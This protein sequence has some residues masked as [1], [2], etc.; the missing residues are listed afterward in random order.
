MAYHS[1]NPVTFAN[2]TVGNISKVSMAAIKTI[3]FLEKE[4]FKVSMASMGRSKII[5]EYA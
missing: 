5:P 2:P 3:I 4:M 1:S